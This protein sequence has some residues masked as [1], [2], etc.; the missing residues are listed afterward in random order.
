MINRL[1]FNVA[2]VA[3]QHADGGAQGL[4]FLRT[5]SVVE[6]AEVGNFVAVAELGVFVR[7]HGRC[8]KAFDG[9]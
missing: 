8:I 1:P 2:P 6:K 7:G 9:Y 3:A 5:L 4:H